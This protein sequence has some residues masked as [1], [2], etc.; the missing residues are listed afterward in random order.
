MPEVRLLIV[1]T[2]PIT[3][4]AILREQPRYLSTHFTVELA[5]TMAGDV[6]DI[7]AVESVPVNPVSMA[8][9]ISPLRDLRSIWQMAAVIRRFRPHIVHSYTPK[10]G[11][12]AM[13]AGWLCRV[14]VRIHTFTGLIFPSQSG[15]K[16]EVL[17]LVDALI[18]LL[19]TRVVP[20]GEGVKED[21]IAHSVTRK[22]LQIIGHGNIAG[23]DTEHYS[24]QA[25]DVMAKAS[26]LASSLNI[27]RDDFVF[28]FVGRLNPDKGI[29]ELIEGFRMLPANSRLLLVGDA[30]D[31]V[32]LDASTMNDLR[33]HA[34]IHALGYQQDIRPALAAS[35]VLVLPS[36]R[37][38]FPNV[39]LQAGAM[40]LPVIATDICGSN[41]IIE[42]GINGWLVPPRD[43][44][45]LAATMR[46][47]MNI[48]EP[49]RA[50][51]G[52]QARQRIRARFER[53]EHWQ[54]M[55]AFY[56]SEVDGQ[57]GA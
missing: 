51:M 29:R 57:E 1:T 37:E 30:D 48:P 12:V 35:D 2:V 33:R 32:P 36:Y 24:R 11:L 7:E 23:V 45:A 27:E 31:T 42:P 49:E 4:R 43:A 25:R 55:V 16:R 3:L 40:N 50:A 54:R 53:A 6:S 47:A 26:L 44:K 56:R 39:V 21:L 14:P 46:E 52:R 13:A 8:R 20:E 22:P 18:C 28:C 19:A 17:R 5:T 34:R 38:G 15:L 10:A 41:E 9:R